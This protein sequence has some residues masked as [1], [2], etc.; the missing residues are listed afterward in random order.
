M[1]EMRIILSA[2]LQDASRSIDEQEKTIEWVT[3]FSSIKTFIS[4]GPRSGRILLDLQNSDDSVWTF[5]DS[6]H[7]LIMDQ[8]NNHYKTSVTN[9]KGRCSIQSKNGLS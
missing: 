9:I 1:G 5:F 2:Q 3:I 7:K 6:Q 8:M 4:I